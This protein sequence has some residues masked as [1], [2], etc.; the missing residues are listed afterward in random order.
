MDA[1]LAKPAPR[2]VPEEIRAAAKHVRMRRL[3]FVEVMVA[4]IAGGTV[5]GLQRIIRTGSFE[6]D[7]LLNSLIGMT[8]ALVVGRGRRH[9]EVG[10]R[11][12]N[13]RHNEASSGGGGELGR[14][15]TQQAPREPR[16]GEWW[17]TPAGR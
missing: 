5:V 10:D 2:E 16:G 14:R 1:L 3:S 13:P 8:I 6:L 4:I 17:S 9:R 12:A 11:S 7:L 15:R